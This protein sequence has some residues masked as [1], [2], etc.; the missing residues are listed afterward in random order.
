MKVERTSAGKKGACKDT[1]VALKKLDKPKA[2]RISNCLLENFDVML[3][4]GPPMD[5]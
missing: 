2:P 1:Q 3:K 4:C 5:N